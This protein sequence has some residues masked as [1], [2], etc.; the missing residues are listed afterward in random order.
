MHPLS[1]LNEFKIFNFSLMK[2]GTL[3]GKH[4][5]NINLNVHHSRRHIIENSES[6][7]P[8]YA[9]LSYFLTVKIRP[10]IRLI[11]LI[12][13]DFLVFTEFK[14]KISE[15]QSYQPN[16]WPKSCKMDRNY[17]QTHNFN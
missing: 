17:S 3:F 8:R 12:S 2:I 6:R 10:Q 9:N 7:P 14:K 5:T 4:L 1:I 11:G 13:T 16:L 15:N